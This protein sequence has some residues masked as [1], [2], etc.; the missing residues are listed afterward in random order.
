M[1]EHTEKN[2]NLGTAFAGR[3]G[4]QKT[5][6]IFVDTSCLKVRISCLLASP[7][8]VLPSFLYVLCTIKISK[9]S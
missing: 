9:I 5:T 4:K 3:G 8:H 1:V 2:G 6:Q 7:D